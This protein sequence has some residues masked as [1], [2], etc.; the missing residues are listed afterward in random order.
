MF[1][2]SP[3]LTAVFVFAGIAVIL[4]F[5]ALLTQKVYVD[6]E[7]ERVT[8]IEAFGVKF[9]TNVPALL[10]VALGFALAGYAY[11]R[12]IVYSDIWTIEAAFQSAEG[13]IP[14]TAS[15]IANL[16][17]GRIVV[18]PSRLVAPPKIA[19][20]GTFMFLYKVYEGEQLDNAIDNIQY[21]DG[22]DFAGTL[23]VG[24][25]NPI[26]RSGLYAKYNFPLHR[27]RH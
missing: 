4:G 3:L 21:L 26:M 22:L 6:T 24:V 9:H 12:S 2:L 25:S 10:F 1:G 17:N 11:Y 8:S 16:K 27:K 19:D 15:E 18:H 5:L 20:D 23:L 13:E 7:N 14:M